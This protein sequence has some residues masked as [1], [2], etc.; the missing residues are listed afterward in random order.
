VLLQG[1]LWLHELRQAVVLH[2]PLQ[3]GA[4]QAFAQVY[5]HVV[6]QEPEQDEL[7]L[8]ASQLCIQVAVQEVLQPP[9]QLV[10]V[11][12][13]LEQDELQV[14]VQVVIHRPVHPLAHYEFD[15]EVEE[16]GAF[17]YKV[18]YDCNSSNASTYFP[19]NIS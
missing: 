16:F 13:P 5:V 2:C 14:A 10:P 19:S 4:E 17:I 1:L 6:R 9:V 7:Q 11:Q 8:P 3:A 12:W 15:A 18:R